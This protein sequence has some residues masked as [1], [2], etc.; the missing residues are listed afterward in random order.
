M[1]RLNEEKDTELK[2]TCLLTRLQTAEHRRHEVCTVRS[3]VNA[4]KSE[5][6][7]LKRQAIKREKLRRSGSSRLLQNSWLSFRDSNRTTKDLALA[8]MNTGLTFLTLHK[9]EASSDG[10]TQNTTPTAELKDPFEEFASCLQSED[11]I[12][13]FKVPFQNTSPFSCFRLLDVFESYEDETFGKKQ[14]RP[15]LFRSFEKTLSQ[16]SEK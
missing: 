13:A 6:Q 7:F 1:R 9:D 14:R 5:T 15:R 11:T 4:E 10:M 8:V 16:N 3:A 12:N 2:R